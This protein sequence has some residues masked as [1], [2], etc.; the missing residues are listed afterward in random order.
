[1]TRQSTFFPHRPGFRRA[2]L[3]SLI[4]A[5][6]A[7]CSEPELTET[8]HLQRAQEFQEQGE[9][10]AAIIELKNVLSVDPDNPDTRLQLGMVYLDAGIGDGAEKELRRAR[11]L[12]ASNSALIVPLAKALLLQG[13]NGALLEE[14]EPQRFP[15]GPLRAKLHALR[16]LA[17]LNQGKPQK[18]AEELEFADTE[19]AS[20]N[21]VLLAHAQLA[22]V[23]QDLDGAREFIDRTLKAE[24]DS[25]DAWALLGNLELSQGNLAEAEAAYGKAIEFRHYPGPEVARRA[26]IRIHTHRFPEAREDIQRLID[27]GFGDHPYVSYVRGMNQFA[28]GHFTAAL[29]AFQDAYAKAPSIGPLNFYLAATHYALGHKEQALA[30]SQRAYAEAPRSLRAKRLLGTLKISYADYDNGRQMLQKLLEERPGDANILRLLAI[31]AMFEGDTSQAVNY[32]SQLVE[33]LP[34]S[35]QAKDLLMMAKLLDGQGLE[36]LTPAKAQGGD[37]TAEFLYALAKLRDSQLAEALELGKGL[38]EK[39]PEKADPHKLIAAVYM[40]VGQWEEASEALEAALQ[41][42][43]DDASAII[44]LAKIRIHG[45]KLEEARALLQKLSRKRPAEE[46]AIL[47]L[48]GLEARLT[49]P[50]AGIRILEEALERNPDSI[51]VRKELASAYLRSGDAAKVLDLTRE[52]DSQTL[53]AHPSFLEY[54]GKAAMLLNDLPSAVRTFRQW[55]QAAPNSAKAYFLYSDALAR[56]GNDTESRTALLQSLKLDPHYLPARIGQVKMLVRSSDLKAARKALADLRTDFGN[57]PEV[58]AIEGWFALGTGDFETAANRLRAALDERPDR[59]VALLLTRALGALQKHQEAAEVL[60]QWLADHPRDQ[61]MSLQLAEVLLAMKKEEAAASLYEKLLQ[62]QP[63]LLVALNNLAWL[64]Q[65]KDPRT[66]MEYA[67]RAYNI[68]PKDP[69]VLDTYGM[70]LKDSGQ[71]EKA[72]RMISEAS[73]LAPENPDIQLHLGMILADQKHY[74]KAKTILAS[75][76]DKA[77]RSQAARE[78]RRLLKEIPQ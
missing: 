72:Y 59:E 29:E 56:S 20:G 39:Y 15:A 75:L 52:L 64:R 40:M 11:E 74:R 68:A 77:P 2:A 30:F 3:A 34:E 65:D 45:G 22:L 12:G 21:E 33:L 53:R 63:D 28:Q 71:K 47:L 66:A 41:R 18:A 38:A 5:A 61:A 16:A 36:D 70:L 73:G 58:L 67:E 37:Y 6:L 69:V 49:T 26:L 46:E 7:G 42:Q 13:K 25:A 8:E 31:G 9:M 1:M 23:R 62:H 14:I 19:D 76:I 44:N 32:L 17:Y 43:P 78:A 51:L 50:R 55:T 54:R 27:A 57:R 24:P 10:R 60:Q 48:A 4:V 35:E